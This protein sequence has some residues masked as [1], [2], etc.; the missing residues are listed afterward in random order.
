[1]RTAKDE[2]RLMD[3]GAALIPVGR[4]TLDTT[5]TIAESVQGLESRIS[6]TSAK[7]S[8]PATVHGSNHTCTRLN[9][10]AA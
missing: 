3:I 5:A 10:S 7:A 8:T 6:N 1:M 2:E 4:R 9:P